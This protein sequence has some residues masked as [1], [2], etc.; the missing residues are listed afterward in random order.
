MEGLKWKKDLNHPYEN[1]KR[2]IMRSL[3]R[4]EALDGEEAELFS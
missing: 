3:P 4:K 2:Q 1:K